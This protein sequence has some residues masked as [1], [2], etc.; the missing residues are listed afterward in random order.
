MSWEKQD[1]VRLGRDFSYK[2][3]LEEIRM[4]KQVK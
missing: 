1:R 3:Y 2:K 4:F